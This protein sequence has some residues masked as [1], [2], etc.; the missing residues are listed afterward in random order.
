MDGSLMIKKYV[1]LTV[2]FPNFPQPFNLQPYF[3]DVLVKKTKLKKTLN[4]IVIISYR[5]FNL[6]FN[7]L[8]FKK[9]N[10]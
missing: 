9:Q 2:C 4:F 10:F 1:P 6:I 3:S 5:Q 8:F 7:L